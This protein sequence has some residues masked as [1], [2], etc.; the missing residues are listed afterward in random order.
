M[1]RKQ[2]FNADNIVEAAF[3]IVRRE[4]WGGLS[5]RT[6]SKELNS[7][8]RPIYSYLDS[9]K[10]LEEE[11]VKKA[12]D[13]FNEYLS[14]ETTGDKWLDQAIGYV[15]FAVNEK[16][17]FRC[18]NDEKH[19][20][21]QRE[22]TPE[23]WESLRKDLTNYEPFKNLSEK[24]IDRIRVM[25]W[26]FIHGIAT[27]INNG[28]FDLEKFDSDTVLETMDTKLIDVINIA[29]YVIHE[30]MK[31]ENILKKLNGV[32]SVRRE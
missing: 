31:D 9:M 5:A 7:S 6:I 11:V 17:L 2:Q 12:L 1:G 29:N 8:T 28:W 15:K 25:R 3:S 13:V 18:I 19:V 21:L 32:K 30:G 16:M 20:D 14:I 23:L 22:N 27:L 26:F 24:Q 4:G 10:T